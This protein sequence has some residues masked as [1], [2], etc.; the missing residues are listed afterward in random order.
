MNDQRISE[1]EVI[2]RVNQTFTDLDRQRSQGLEQLKTLQSNQNAAL[3]RERLRLT[4]KY[5]ADHP[6]VQ[7]ITARLSYNQGMFKELDR[8]IARSQ[9]ETPPFDR[10]TW[11]VPG[12][13]R[14]SQG[15]GVKGL[16]ISFSDGNGRWV[17][18]LGY[19]CTN[20]SGNFTFTY[21]K[22]GEKPTIPATQPLF[23]T[24]T[25]SERRILYRASQ[26][27]FV[28][29]GL[30]EPFQEITLDEEVCGT[31]PEGHKPSVPVDVQSIDAPTQLTVNQSGTFTA[32]INPDATPP[33]TYHWDFGDGST[34]TKLTVTHSYAAVGTYTVK[35]TASNQESTDFQ[36]TQVAVQ[37]KPIPPVIEKLSVSPR[38]PEVNMPLRFSATVQGDAPIT[39]QWNFGDGNTSE[40]LNPSHSYKQA[41]LYQI[42]LKVTNA[43][44]SNLR[45]ASLSIAESTL[46]AWVVKGRVTD[47]TG[48]GWEGLTVKLY[49]RDH[50]FDDRLGTTQ[51]NA[52]GEFTIIYRTEDFDDLF[53]ARPD[54]YLKI[55]DPAGNNLYSSEDSVRCNAGRVEVFN[56][57]IPRN[58]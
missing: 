25:D 48:R 2:N 11:M 21:P 30:I 17:K 22:Q 40:E 32:T 16:T 33:L 14:T 10:N 9:I 29:I 49:D 7:K 20:D 56:I 28:R 15:V 41:G 54:L 57:T 8:E 3:E 37:A 45:S 24:V 42:T 46:D 36:S 26:P 6:R 43:G 31:P 47:E 12:R 38:N 1:E 50:F 4:N 19:T 18:Q 35:F 52:N 13:V 34:D 5:G 27:L 44:G 23:V 53:D 39:Y 55:L 58:P 51:T